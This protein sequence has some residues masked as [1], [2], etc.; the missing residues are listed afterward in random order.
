MI[1]FT[2]FILF[3]V[4]FWFVFYLVKLGPEQQKLQDLR[5][6]GAGLQLEI[7]KIEQNLKHLQAEREV[8]DSNDRFYIK[9][10]TREKLR[11]QP[12]G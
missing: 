5:D 11:L 12:E 10:L 3:S 7:N 8:L 1:I 4:F 9:R 2:R 6:R